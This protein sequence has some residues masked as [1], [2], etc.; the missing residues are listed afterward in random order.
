MSDSAKSLGCRARAVVWVRRVVGALVFLSF[1][2]LFA[3]LE[4]RVVSWLAPLAKAQYATA[5]LAGNI[6]VAAVVTA[7]T[8][9]C[10]RLY[11]SVLCPLGLLQDLS[12]LPGRLVRR[13]LRRPPPPVGPAARRAQLAGYERVRAALGNH[14]CAHNAATVILNLLKS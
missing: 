6:V 10:G 8:I 13:L 9:L 4:W 7:V 14:D 2:A 3:G 1:A 5:I 11:C 12:N